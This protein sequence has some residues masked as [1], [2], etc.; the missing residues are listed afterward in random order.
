MTPVLRGVSLPLRWIAYGTAW[1]YRRCRESYLSSL[2]RSMRAPVAVIFAALFLLWL[3]YVGQTYI[4]RSLLPEVAQGVIIADVEYPVGT[5]LTGTT[6]R[7]RW[8]VSQLLQREEVKRVD[9]MIGQ[10][11]SDEQPG[12]RRGPHQAKLTILLHE[13][14]AESQLR[15]RLHT[16]S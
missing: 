16:L 15:H 13:A 6:K 9:V 2:N 5:S 4:P 1:S 12:E 11:Q 8:W 14:S 10:D 3:S 7:I